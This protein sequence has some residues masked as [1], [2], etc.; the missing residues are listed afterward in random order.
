MSL[1]NI[2][3]QVQGVV[4]GGLLILSILVPNIVRSL[5]SSG[6][7]FNASSLVG[8]AVA[9]VVFAAFIAFFFW[10]RAALVAGS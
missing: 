9:F 2:Q 1:L 7:R 8:A 4:I 10:S 6:R 5:A 3:G